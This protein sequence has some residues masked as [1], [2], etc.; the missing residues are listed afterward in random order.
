M[1]IHPT[2]MKTN[3]RKKFNFLTNSKSKKEINPKK[4]AKRILLNIK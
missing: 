3:M 1:I 4:I 2:A